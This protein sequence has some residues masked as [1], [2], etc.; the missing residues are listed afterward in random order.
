MGDTTISCCIWGTY[1]P[2]IQ[3]QW[4][5]ILYHIESKIMLSINGVARIFVW[6]A[7]RPMPPGRFCIISRIRPDIGGGG[8]GGSGIIFFRYQENCLNSG[9]FFYISGDLEV[10]RHFWRPTGLLTHSK[11]K[12]RN[13]IISLHRNTFIR[14]LGGMAPVATPWIRHCYLSFY[15]K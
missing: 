10:T 11:F 13:N 1:L 3:P 9:R 15:L 4:M 12:E 7:T 14:S 6:G 8:G 2:P 5:Q